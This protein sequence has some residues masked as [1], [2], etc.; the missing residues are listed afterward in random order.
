MI[1][2]AVHFVRH[3]KRKLDVLGRKIH[4]AQ[5]FHNFDGVAAF[6]YFC[7]SALLH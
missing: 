3:A 7:V 1:Q 6:L 5:Q 4:M 2:G